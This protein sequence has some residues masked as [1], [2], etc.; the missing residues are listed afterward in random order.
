MERDRPGI[1]LCTPGVKGDGLE[2]EVTVKVDCGDDMLESEDVALMVVRCCCLRV[3]D[4]TRVSLE[5]AAAAVSSSS[6]SS[7]SDGSRC[8]ERGLVCSWKCRRR[9]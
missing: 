1:V 7:S 9:R 8:A 2:V 3:S 6:S 5:A 4:V